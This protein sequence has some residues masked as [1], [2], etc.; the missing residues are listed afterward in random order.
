M[1][2]WGGI[3]FEGSDGSFPLSVLAVFML[4]LTIFVKGLSPCFMCSTFPSQ[5]SKFIRQTKRN[6]T[7]LHYVFVQ[8]SEWTSG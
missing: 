7:T 6:K 5:R 8:V 4:S 3:S 1:S 2:D